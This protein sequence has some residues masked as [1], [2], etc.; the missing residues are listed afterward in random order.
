MSKEQEFVSLKT[1]TIV[2]KFENGVSKEDIDSGKVKPYEVVIDED[3]IKV[4][5]DHAIALGFNIDAME[6]RNKK[7][8]EFRKNNN[9]K[10]G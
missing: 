4:T 7:M 1:R 6:K 5:R 10:E 3:E 8:E 2:E 9:V